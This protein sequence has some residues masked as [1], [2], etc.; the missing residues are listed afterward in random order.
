VTAAFVD[1]ELHLRYNSALTVN[2]MLRIEAY[3]SEKYGIPL[4]GESAG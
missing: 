3:L 2:E 1:G 4:E